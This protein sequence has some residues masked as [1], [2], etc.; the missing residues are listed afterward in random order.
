MSEKN[1]REWAYIFMIFGCIQFLILT[2]LAMIFYAGGTAVNKNASGYSFWAN[3]FSDTGMVKAWS[4]RDNTIS[5]ILL[6]VTLATL[7][8]VVIPFNLAFQQI[9]NE[10]SREKKL[11][12]RGSLFGILFGIFVIPVAF[13]PLDIYPMEHFLF[14]LIAFSALLVS[15]LIYIVVILSSK[16]YPH[17]YSYTYLTF[18]V[19]Y[20]IYYVILMS[21][22]FGGPS[23]ST[24]EGLTIQATAQKVVI[25]ALITWLLIQSYGGWKQIKS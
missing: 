25:Y 9:F 24:A 16:S 4:G 7:G 5:Y 21:M 3:F 13:T 22:L 14:T 17:L 1:W 6:T 2:T 20:C 8:V 11:S 18:V 23:S 12:K 15:V 10:S 19:I